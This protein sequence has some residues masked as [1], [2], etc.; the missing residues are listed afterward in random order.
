MSRFAFI[1]HQGNEIGNNLADASRSIE[2]SLALK[3]GEMWKYV[4]HRP[5]SFRKS[6]GLQVHGRLHQTTPPKKGNIFVD[7]MI[8]SACVVAK[9]T[10]RAIWPTNRKRFE[11]NYVINVKLTH[12]HDCESTSSVLAKMG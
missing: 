10:S 4:R 3:Y 6:N 8:M 9:A 5:V 7:V 1:S 11:A 12:L 2:L